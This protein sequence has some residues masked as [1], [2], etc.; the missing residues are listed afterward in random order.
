MKFSSRHKS[1]K[2]ESIGLFSLLLKR[3]C[4][5]CYNDSF[6]M[7]ANHFRGEIDFWNNSKITRIYKFKTVNNQEKEI[8]TLLDKKKFSLTGEE[9]EYFDQNPRTINFLL[10]ILL[11]Q[12][13]DADWKRTYHSAD[14]MISNFLVLLIIAYSFWNSIIL[15]LIE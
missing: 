5:N 4:H 7:P 2:W 13:N 10:F 1:A 11:H 8:P 9:F 6:L 3:K 12:N 14:Y 15:L